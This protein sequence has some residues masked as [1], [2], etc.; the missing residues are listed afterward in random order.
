MS[1][2]EIN[3]NPLS[4]AYEKD[5]S[6]LNTAYDIDGDVIFSGG[7]DYDNY[8]IESLFTISVNNCQGIA[9]NNGVLFQFR[10]GGGVSD[11]LCLFNASTGADITRNMTIESDHGDSATFSTSKYDES[12]EFPLIYVTADT[13]PAK[14]YIDRVSRSSASLIKT[15]VFPSSA[16]YYGAGAFD[17]ENNICYI[18]AYAESNY[19][20]DD[21]GANT[22]VISKWD[23]TNLTDNGDSTYTPAFISQYDRAFIYCMQG[24]EYHDG[25]IW[26]A[27]GY[28]GNSQSYVYAINPSNGQLLHT[29]DLNT[30]TEVEGVAFISDTEMVVGLQGG[31]YKK[32]TFAEL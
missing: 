22:T 23:L 7:V 3:G 9:I 1:I 12:D 19:L 17:F 25:M 11:T 15:L 24:L 27:S 28:S 6:T 18:L 32:V 4:I 16:G 26:V 10:G 29:I 21:G 30:T 2:Y 8:T 14:I 20:T 5:G 31:V 13:T